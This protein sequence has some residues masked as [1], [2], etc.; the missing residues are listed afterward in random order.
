MSSNYEALVFF[1]LDGTLLNE[2]SRVSPTTAEAISELRKNRVLPV[3]ATARGPFEVAGLL[4]DTKIDAFVALNGQYVVVHGRPV[5]RQQIEL[6]ILESL[7]VFAAE[8][9]HAMV[10]YSDHDYALSKIDAVAKEC[11]YRDHAP[12]PQCNPDFYLQNPIYQVY[13]HFRDSRFD[14]KYEQHFQQELSFSRDTD[15][16]LSALPKGTSKGVGIDYLRQ[17]LQCEHLPTFAFGDGPNDIGMFDAVET[18]VAMGNAHG[19]IKEY[20]HYVTRKNT[21]DGIVHGLRHLGLIS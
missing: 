18:R 8:R 1:D 6:P 21:E 17:Y 9:E 19:D 20:A 11:F 4:S 12:L 3:V 5:Y 13:L 7:N 2:N 15:I 16:S 14:E 10:Y